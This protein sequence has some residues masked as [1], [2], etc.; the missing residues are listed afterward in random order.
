MRARLSME[1][2]PIIK[3]IMLFADM[4]SAI[5]IWQLNF[6]SSVT[7]YKR[8]VPYYIIYIIISNSIS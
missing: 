3:E 4:V 5:I 6:L 8:K 1:L 7:I 2:L